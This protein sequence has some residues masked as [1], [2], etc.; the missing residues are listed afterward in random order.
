MNELSKIAEIAIPLWAV[1][2]YLVFMCAVQALPRPEQGAAPFYVWLYQFAH[3]LC[4]NL[5]LVIDPMKKFKTETTTDTMT[6]T[7][8]STAP[9]VELP[10]P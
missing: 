7:S 2:S 8:T 10:K 3:L 9:T 4:M 1:A 6:I 5:G